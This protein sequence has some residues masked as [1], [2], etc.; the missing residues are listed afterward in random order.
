MWSEYER[1]GFRLVVIGDELPLYSHQRRHKKHPGDKDDLACRGFVC[2]TLH[3]LG[4]NVE[5]IKPKLQ[6]AVIDWVPSEHAD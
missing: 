1:G 5:T 4:L 3:R 6:P 2:R